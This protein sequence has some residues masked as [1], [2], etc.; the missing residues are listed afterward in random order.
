[1]KLNQNWMLV[2]VLLLLSSGCGR[3]GSLYLPEKDH[4]QNQSLEHSGVD[5]ASEIP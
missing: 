4:D 2:I 1:M 5:S 3:K